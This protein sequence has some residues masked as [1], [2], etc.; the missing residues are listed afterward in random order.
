[1][2]EKDTSRRES[3]EQKQVAHL[4][5]HHRQPKCFCEDIFRHKSLQ[6][7]I[8]LGLRTP[9]YW[10]HT[11]YYFLGWNPANI[12][13]SAEKRIVVDS[14]RGAAPGVCSSSSPTCFG[15]NWSFSQENKRSRCK[16]LAGSG[17][18]AYYFQHGPSCPLSMKWDIRM[19]TVQ[20]VLAKNQESE[21]SGSWG[22][23]RARSLPDPLPLSDLNY[24]VK[25]EGRPNPTWHPCFISFRRTWQTSPA[26]SLP[27]PTRRTHWRTRTSL[28]SR[29][30]LCP[31][32]STH[33][34]SA[35]HKLSWHARTDTEE[36]DFGELCKWVVGSSLTSER[37]FKVHLFLFYTLTLSI[38]FT[39]ISKLLPTSST[40]D[41]AVRNLSRC[42]THFHP[43]IAYKN[44]QPVHTNTT[45]FFISSLFT[46]PFSQLTKRSTDRKSVV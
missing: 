14:L 22:F 15:R 46:K 4:L 27:S 42:L 39:H 18:C 33:A 35:V 21:V 31:A 8:I 19:Q 5:L 45:V 26:C 11:R 43:S 7:L 17:L 40:W 34:Y 37:C 36:Q 38:A 32:Q 6:M 2:S 9:Q 28:L 41:S 16:A 23:S 12:A 13:R 1:M 30:L 44:I 10:S 3:Y 20:N 25:G 24:R 29:Q